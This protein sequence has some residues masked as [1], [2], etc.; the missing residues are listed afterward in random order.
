MFLGMT[1][2]L[3][4]V[5]AISEPFSTNR[6]AFASLAW[7]GVAA[8]ATSAPR[9]KIGTAVAMA[10]SYCA[11][12][13]AHIV[14]VE[15]DDHS[16]IDRNPVIDDPLDLDEQIPFQVLPLFGFAQA[17]LVG[18]LDTDKYVCQAGIGAHPQHFSVTGGVDGDLC[19]EANSAVR[20]PRVPVVDGGEQLLGAGAV[21]GEIVVRKKDGSISVPIQFI[22]FAQHQIDGLVPLLAPDIFDHV[23]KLALE[24]TPTRK[25]GSCP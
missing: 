15:T 16:A 9:L 25:S 11:A 5:A 3:Q 12:K 10:N 20:L 8:G 14:V 19:R 2:V 18:R 22:E 4:G 17:R 13:N 1:L 21:D 6:P 24:R 23:A 7:S